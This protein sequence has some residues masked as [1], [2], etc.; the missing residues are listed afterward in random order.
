MDFNRI[1]VI[2][3]SVRESLNTFFIF[4]YSNLASN[5]RIHTQNMY[6]QIKIPSNAIVLGH[7]FFLFCT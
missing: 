1:N 4:F 7:P 2:N 5:V 3:R 6:D